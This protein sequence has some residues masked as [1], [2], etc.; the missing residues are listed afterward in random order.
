MPMFLVS[1]IIQLALVVHAIKTGRNTIW[2]FIII[3]APVVGTLAYVIVELLP[4]L[5]GSR[6][7]RNAKAKLSQAINPGK[8]LR[9][10]EERYALAGTVKNAMLLAEQFLQHERCADARMMYTRC[11]TG[12]YADDPH[13]LLGLA[14]A[15]Y[16][17]QEYDEA[18]RC[19]DQLK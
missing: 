2:I 4:E 17:L 5:I 18:L 3:F 1:I 7:G 6:S 13:L 14:T 11:L 8:G 16:G 10:A 12:I 19:L 15:H 9:E